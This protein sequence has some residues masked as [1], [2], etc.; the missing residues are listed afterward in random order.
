MANYDKLLEA[1]EE[2][3]ELAEK[4]SSVINKLTQLL[5]QYISV[6]ELEELKNGF[7]PSCRDCG[8]SRILFHPDRQDRDKV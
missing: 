3:S 6:E 2:L 8:V 7:Q 5:A 1:V 4:Q